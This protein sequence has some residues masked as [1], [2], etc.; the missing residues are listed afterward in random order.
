MLLDKYRVMGEMPHR[1]TANRNR[2]QTQGLRPAIYAKWVDLLD[3]DGCLALLRDEG[4]LPSG[5]PGLVEE[6]MM[7]R[8]T[9]NPAACAVGA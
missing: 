1:T 7:W 2:G 3:F 8:L 6:R 4:V 9:S 5:V